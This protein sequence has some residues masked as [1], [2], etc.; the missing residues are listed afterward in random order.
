MWILGVFCFNNTFTD[1]NFT[2]LILDLT[3]L[4]DAR[5]KK[6]KFYINILQGLRNS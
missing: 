2:I 6:L 3:Q 5:G 1:M 4:L